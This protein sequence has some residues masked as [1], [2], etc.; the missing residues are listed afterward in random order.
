MFSITLR[1]GELPQNLINRGSCKT[2]VF[3]HS[4]KKVCLG[5]TLM[6]SLQDSIAYSANPGLRFAPT[7]AVTCRPYRPTKTLLTRPVRPACY[8]PGRSEAEAWVS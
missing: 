2:P 6:P 1:S 8:S 5:N 4:S 3:C 7:W